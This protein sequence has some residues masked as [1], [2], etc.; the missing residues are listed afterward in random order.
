[1]M[2]TDAKRPA[3]AGTRSLDDLE[4]HY[5]RPLVR[6]I[7]SHI[8]GLNL[9]Q[10]SPVLDALDAL[11]NDPEKLMCDIDALFDL[12]EV[13]HLIIRAKVRARRAG[14]SAE[15]L[16]VLT[17]Q[18]HYIRLLLEKAH[19]DVGRLVQAENIMHIVPVCLF[20]VGCFAVCWLILHFSLSALH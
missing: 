18:T 17:D 15:T 10:C 7:R 19:S 14:A 12:D 13:F 4:E 16:A 1:M 9:P 11:L 20:A 2:T 8:A 6:T 3:S 5:P